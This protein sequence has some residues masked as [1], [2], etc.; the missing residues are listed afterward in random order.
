MADP[1]A[2]P[3]PVEVLA[4]E[5]LERRRQGQRPTIAEYSACYPDLADQIRACFPA[6]LLVEDLKPAS[7][8]ATGPVGGAAV[9]EPGRPLERLGDYRLLREVGRGGMGVVYEAEQESLGRRVALKV[10]AAPALLDPQRVRRFLREARAAAGLHHSN[11]VPVFGVGEHAGVHYFVMQFIAGLGLDAVLAEL[12]RLQQARSMPAAAGPD[13]AADSA[14]AAVP[15]AAPMAQ[16]LLTG[17]FPR[18]STSAGQAESGSPPEADALSA[19]GS[20]AVLHLPG[21]AEHAPLSDSGRAYW[22][23]V[24]RIGVQIAQAL[25]YAHEQGILHRDI[26]PSNL[27]LD[28][29]GTVW[30]T[31][32]GLAKAAAEKDNLTHTGDLVGTVRYM[33]PERFQGQ[34][35][36]RSDV[37][38]LGLTLYELLTQRPAFDEADRNRLIHQVTETEPPRLRKRT[39]SLPRDLE[40]IVHKAIEKEPAHRYA[41]AGA[42][43]EDLRRFLEDRPIRARRVSPTE[44]LWRWCRRNPALATATGLATVALVA[45]TAVSVLFASHQARSNWQLRDEQVKTQAEKQKAE[46]HAEESRQRLVRVQVSTGARL[47]EQRDQ[48]GA[49]PWFAEALRLDQGDPAREENHRLRLAAALQRSPK[50]VALWST[51]AG[52]GQAVFCP[53]G[54]RVA[55]ARIVPAFLREALAPRGKGVLEIWDVAT[56][57]PTLTLEHD[58]ALTGFEFSPDGS[59]VATASQDGTARVWNLDT[60]QPVTP[61][62]RHAGPVNSVAFRPDG[63][64]LATT[65]DDKTARLWDAGSGEPLHS[66]PH[67]GAVQ[68]ASFSPDG[69]RLVTSSVGLIQ[70]WNAADGQAVTKPLRAEQSP[71]QGDVQFSADGRRI[72]VTGGQRVARLWDA[73]TGELRSRT[74]QRTH[75]H[76]Q[77]WLSPDRS[78]AVSSRVDLPPQVWD[79]LTGEPVTPPLRHLPG[80]VRAAFSP[81]GDRVVT[82]GWDGTVRVW[83]LATGAVVAGPLGHGTLFT[84][85]SFSPDG[86]LVVTRDS[87][88]LVRVWD[89]A[90][91]TPTLSPLKSDEYTAFALFSPDGRWAVTMQPGMAFSLWDVGTGRLVR[92]IPGAGQLLSASFHPDGQRLLTAGTN[93]MA[94][95]W[96][97]TTGTPISAP[98]RHAGWVTHAEFSPDGRL[99]LTASRDKTA[100]LW[101][102]ATGQLLVTLPH[103]REVLWASF[104][105]DGQQIVTATGNLSGLLLLPLVIDPRSTGEARVWETATGRPVTPW[106]RHEGAVQRAVF[107]PDGRFFLTTCSGGLAGRHQA[108][109]WEAA[110]GRPVGPALVHT[111]WGLHG[112]FSPDGRLLVTAS[113]DGIAR[114]WD[115][116]TGKALLALAEHTGPVGHVAFSPD[117]RRLVTASDDGTAR[118]WETG[119]GQ[120]VTVLRH[121]QGVRYAAFGPD[122]YSVVTGCVDG[123]ARVWRLT[124][125]HRPVDDWIALANLLAGGWTDPGRDVAP[126]NLLAPDQTWRALRSKYPGDFATAQD[127]QLAWHRAALEESLQKQAWPAA[128][129]QVGRLLDI[130]PANGQDRLARARLLARLERWDEAEAEFTRA[131]ERHPDNPHVWVARGSFYLGRGQKDQAAADLVKAIGL[132]PASQSA[133]VLSDYWVAGAYPEDLKTPFPPEN[134][135]DPS[136]PIPAAAGL[137]G[138]LQARRWQGASTDAAGHLDLAACFDQAEH[139]TTYALTYVYAKTEQDVILWAGSDDALRL[140]LNGELKHEFVTGRVAL[141]DQDRVPVTLRAGWNVLLAKV[142]NLTGRHGLYLRLSTEPARAS[143]EKGRPDG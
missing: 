69:K 25:Q 92:M 71:I 24:A 35:D 39:P 134:Q 61:P 58:A 117:G 5:F 119:T 63:R 105:P 135:T 9:L 132:Q 123:T 29:Q 86:R 41:T 94:R 17:Q 62:L 37:Y 104:G 2:D 79:L 56:R 130:D 43:A 11:I 72:V 27:L 116:A 64:W 38:G 93:G 95:V 66:L 52:A 133:A 82:T 32:F 138:V 124:P 3:N 108:Q 19:P 15:S 49:L 45:A 98:L 44:R 84:S 136:Q 131:V 128:L 28:G 75:V 141:P 118:V 87:D 85:A 48:H 12:K 113:S 73:D 81:Q 16:G 6:L 23:S 99:V 142:V 110:T 88:G 1:C 103:D 50:L 90:G 34:C 106:I 112:S 74:R 51:E 80:A 109:V 14:R 76:S 77:A 7:A 54:R 31:D 107:S 55:T 65:A 96:Q 70:V 60:G 102:A 120:P 10:L 13:P 18:P 53:D 20:D 42:L 115:A 125:D 59:R 83:D 57:R 68:A 129:V 137:A 8:D 47:L 89:L 30:V 36:A 40:T 140:W 4:E 91:I 126:L 143:A 67:G 101:D 127:E 114:V 33:A 22:Q 46:D 78:S 21:Q 26:K 121:A 111:E 100:R 122:G 97:T 139:I